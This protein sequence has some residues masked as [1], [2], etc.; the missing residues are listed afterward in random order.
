M[1]YG[2]YIRIN[3]YIVGCKYKYIDGKFEREEELIDT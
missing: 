2:G 1:E 3:R